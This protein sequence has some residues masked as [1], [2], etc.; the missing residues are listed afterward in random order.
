MFYQQLS[1]RQGFREESD[2]L[3][4]KGMRGFNEEATKRK[5]QHGT[6]PPWLLLPLLLLGEQ[7]PQPPSLPSIPVPSCD[8]TPAEA[9][10]RGPGY[11]RGRGQGELGR[12]GGGVA[13]RPPH[14]RLLEG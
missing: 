13:G 9:T 6:G 10:T 12:G 8:P 7:T 5:G 3:P 4:Q 2:G 11:C 1:W 14:P